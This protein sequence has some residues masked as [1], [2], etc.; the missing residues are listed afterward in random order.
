MYKS[1]KGITSKQ[2]MNILTLP[3]KSCGRFVVIFS[4]LGLFSGRF[5][6]LIQESFQLF[7]KVIFP[8]ESSEFVGALLFCRE[9]E[10]ELR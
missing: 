4:M 1:Q 2:Q 10:K 9:P 8:S 6:M 7:K 3:F 5:A